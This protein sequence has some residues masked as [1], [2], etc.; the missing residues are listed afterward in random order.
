MNGDAMAGMK[1]VS[2]E[3]LATYSN[4]IQVIDENKEFTSVP[5]AAAA[6]YAC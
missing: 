2:P 3:E 4:G 6:I 5:V 1:D